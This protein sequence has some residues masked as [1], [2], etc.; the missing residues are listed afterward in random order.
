MRKMH[1][2]FCLMILPVMAFSQKMYRGGEIYSLDS[3]QYGKVEMRMKMAKG[4]GMLSTFFTYKNGSEIPGTFWEEIDI[5]VLG[6]EDATGLQ[7]NIITGNPRETSEQVY[8]VDSSL[9]DDYHTYTLEWTPEYVAW[10]LDGVLIRK[11]EGEQVDTL[12]N[13]QTFRMNIWAAK[14]VEW[15]GE[16]DTEALP[17]YQFVNW[18]EYSAYT[19]GEGDNGGD[20]TKKWRDNFNSFDY[21]KWGK[22]N[23]TFDG[24]LVHFTPDNVV[25]KDGYLILIISKAGDTGYEGVVPRDYLEHVG[26]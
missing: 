15:V 17:A 21:A 13:P 6:K 8:T 9:A 24:N 11:S 7:S 22:A 25:V 23:W 12:N 5:E 16:F 2:I 14:W 18:I 4:S 1:L 3:W 26:R 10:Y 19:P 20:F